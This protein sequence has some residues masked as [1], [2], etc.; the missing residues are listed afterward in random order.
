[1]S[2]Y[3]DS[4]RDLQ[5]KFET[6][7]LADTLDHSIVQS[8]LDDAACAFIEERVFFFL[9]T[10]SSEGE[11]TVSHK[12]GPKGTV[13]VLDP[14]TL[15]FPAYDGNGMFLSL[16]NIADT[17]KIG[18]LFMDFETPHR[19]RVQASATIVQDQSLLAA[20]P[21]AIAVVKAHIDRTFVNCARY[22][23]KY[24]R[25]ESSRHVPDDAGEQPLASWKRIKGMGPLLSSED[26]ARAEGQEISAQDYADLL[27][28]GDS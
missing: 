6:R 13:K 25:V 22:I 20:F 14:Q 8:E 4:Q 19:V 27:A 28:R 3:T 9:T 10:V 2:S 18:L 24:K 1:M 21:G 7:A 12:G 11:P 23:H 16:G 15:V 17:G 26:Q 5:D